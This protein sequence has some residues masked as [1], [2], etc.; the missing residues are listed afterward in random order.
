MLGWY[1]G[2]IAEPDK[3]FPFVD[4][5]HEAIGDITLNGIQCGPVA[6]ITMRIVWLGKYVASAMREFSVNKVRRV[7]IHV[8][9]TVGTIRS[10]Q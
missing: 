2:E 5:D 8:S 6:W 7:K 10:Q 1:D 9:C 4:P 3:D